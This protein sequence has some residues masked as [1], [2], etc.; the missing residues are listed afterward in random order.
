M[1]DLICICILSCVHA[2]S[3]RLTFIIN[4]VHCNTVWHSRDNPHCC[5]FRKH[6][7]VSNEALN[8]L[9]DAVVDCAVHH[10]GHVTAYLKYGT[11]LSTL[12]VSGTYTEGECK[13]IYTLVTVREMKM[14]ATEVSECIQ[15][16]IMASNT[17]YVHT[18]GYIIHEATVVS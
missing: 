6:R 7:Q 4:N 9:S 15:W 10:C 12:V 14:Q 5:H 13:H 16:C 8:T 2:I 3:F 17:S 18:K 1:L 11:P